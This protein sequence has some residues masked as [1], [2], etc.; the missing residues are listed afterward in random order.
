MGWIA[1][2]EQ[3]FEINATP[4]Q[5]KVQIACMYYGEISDTLVQMDPEENSGVDM[6]AVDRGIA[7]E[8]QWPQGH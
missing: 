7:K 6:G 3:Y 2:A 4:P 8:I 5:N 1:S